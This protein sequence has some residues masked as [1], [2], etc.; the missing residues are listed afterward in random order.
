MTGCKRSTLKKYVSRPS[1]AFPANQCQGQT[2]V[3]NDG[4]TYKSVPDK[5]GIHTWKKL[6]STRKAAKKA[7]G[8]S[9]KIHNN[10][11]VPFTVVDNKKEKCATILKTTDGV[12]VKEV[13]YIN[14]WPSSASSEAFGD[15]EPGNSVLIQKD[16]QTYVAVIRQS[17][18]EFQ[19]EKDDAV[20]EYMSPIGN[21]DVPY[22]YIIGQSHVYLLTE[23]VIVPKDSLDLTKDVYEQYYGINDFKGSKVKSAAKKLKMK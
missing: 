17:I 10:G 13:K 15:W 3:G 11:Y 4:T 19:L 22:P 9:Y 8:K 7:S 16:K 21:N 1:P 6:N 23:S 2:M 20:V 18:V 5:R 12:K 14:F